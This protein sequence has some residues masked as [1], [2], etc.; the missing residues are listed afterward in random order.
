MTE[1][2][3][4]QMVGR[5]LAWSLPEGFNPDGG[6]SFKAEFN[7]NTP[8]PLKHEPC[9]MNLLDYSQGAHSGVERCVSGRSLASQ[10]ITSSAP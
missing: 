4:N 1:G 9:G 6:I 7:E 2:H 8:H 5:F 10:G 3:I